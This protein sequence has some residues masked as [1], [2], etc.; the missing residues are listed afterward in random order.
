M[1]RVSREMERTSN[2]IQGSAGV[3]LDQLT[4]Y[5][6]A[7]SQS[8]DVAYPAQQGRA[9]TTRSPLAA[10]I[11]HTIYQQLFAVSSDR[12]RVGKDQVGDADG[13]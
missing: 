8:W 2:K 13:V 1:E 4:G 7:S 5:G 10:I 3:P 11:P 9:T 6:N 12:G